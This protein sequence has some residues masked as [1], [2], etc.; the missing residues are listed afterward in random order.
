MPKQSINYASLSDSERKVLSVL[1]E[2]ERL[3]VNEIAETTNEN[4]SAINAL[5]IQLELKHCVSKAIDGK[6]EA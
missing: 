1:Q 5:M 3:S 6:Y 2:G 4:I